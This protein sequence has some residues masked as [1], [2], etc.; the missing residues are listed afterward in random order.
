MDEQLYLK[1]GEA[2]SQLTEMCLGRYFDEGRRDVA[3]LPRN[4]PTTTFSWQ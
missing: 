4:E 2:I 3:P 1:F